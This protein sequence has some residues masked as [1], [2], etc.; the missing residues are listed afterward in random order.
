VALL[1]FSSLVEEERR[2]PFGMHILSP[3]RTFEALEIAFGG[4]K[5]ISKASEMIF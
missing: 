2:R 5:R 1:F 3:N 4:Q